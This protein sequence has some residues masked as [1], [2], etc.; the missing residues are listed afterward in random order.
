MCSMEESLPL[1][2][3]HFSSLQIYSFPFMNHMGILMFSL[4]TSCL[5]KLGWC[6]ITDSK[7]VKS[8]EGQAHNHRLRGS[9]FCMCKKAATKG[10]LAIL[11]L[12][13]VFGETAPQL[14]AFSLV[15]QQ[16]DSR[17]L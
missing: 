4:R 16:D 3:A 2:S 7:V 13:L 6:C 9:T 10:L 14:L 12:A 17:E 8:L 1:T 11:D 15:K 5:S